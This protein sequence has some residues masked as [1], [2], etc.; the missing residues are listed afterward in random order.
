MRLSSIEEVAFFVP[1][2]LAGCLSA[3]SPP[4]LGR[5]LT[6]SSLGG[7]ASNSAT[8]SQKKR[9]KTP[10]T[11]HNDRSRVRQGPLQYVLNR[12]ASFP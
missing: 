6:P 12:N 7:G 1:T 8:K 5:R 11:A 4:D 3:S 9:A 10:E 2:L